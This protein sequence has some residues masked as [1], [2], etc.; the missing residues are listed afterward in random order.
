MHPY[1]SSH[2]MQHAFF[3]NVDRICQCQMVRLGSLVEVATACPSL[4]CA[5]AST[6]HAPPFIHAS[7]HV[8]N[9]TSCSRTNEHDAR[10]HFTVS[11][12]QSTSMSI[13]QLNTMQSTTTS[14]PSEPECMTWHHSPCGR[15]PSIV[16]PPLHLKLAQLTALASCSRPRWCECLIAP[17]LEASGA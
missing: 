6:V 12:W 3:R 9:L 17:T 11:A 7:M 14:P 10:R 13:M 5:T 15:S 1:K 16:A 2:A 8:D 4:I